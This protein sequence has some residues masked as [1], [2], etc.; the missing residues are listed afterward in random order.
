MDELRF[1][2]LPARVYVRGF[3]MLFASSVGLDPNAVAVSY[4]QRFDHAHPQPR[5]RFSKGG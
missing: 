1:A 4:L 5:G 3:V 2:D